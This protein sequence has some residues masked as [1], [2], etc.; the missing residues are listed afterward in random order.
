[1]AELDLDQDGGGGG[2]LATKKLIIIIVA[3]L[4]LLSAG[5]AGVYFFMKGSSNE[6]HEESSDEPK[7][8]KKAANMTLYFDMSKALIV[9]FPKGSPMEIVQIATSF[10]VADQET[11]DALKKIEP[12]LR[13]N[14]LLI[15]GSQSADSLATTAGKELL[16]KAMLDDVTATLYKLKIHGEV[17]EVLFTSFI[18][19]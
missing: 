2:K 16:R 18:M 7:A 5:G 8:H 1:M 14:L 6:S 17:L 15:I 19:Q 10:V 12:V 9:D 11:A 3:G 4:L 13:N